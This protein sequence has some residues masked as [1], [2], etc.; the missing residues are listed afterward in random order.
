MSG[1]ASLPANPTPAFQYPNMGSAA[2]G[3]LGGAN[4]ISTGAQNINSA[5]GAGN[6]NTTANNLVTQGGSLAGQAQS[7]LSPTAFNPAQYSQQYQQMLDQTNA[8]NAMNG[9]SGTPYGAGV[10][11]TASQNFNNNWNQQ[12]IGLE[13]TA[14][15]TASTLLGAG[16]NAATAGTA[17]GQSIATLP[18]NEQQQAIQDYLNYLGGGTA[19]ANAG[20]S[21]YSAEA[22]A[23]LQN[24]QLQ[25]QTLGG[26]GSLF[27]SLFGGAGGLGGLGSTLGSAASTLAFL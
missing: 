14:A 4:N 16:T 17:L 6:A 25:N 15:N 8:I 27:G 2:S 18:L 1:G 10:A 20:T 22:N 13:N 9:V 23:Q 19:A 11:N 21:Q 12:Q 26:I 7:A 3:A 5:Y 24:Q